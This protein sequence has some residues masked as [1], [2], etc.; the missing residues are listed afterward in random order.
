MS[1]FSPCG[2]APPGSPL[3]C[4]PRGSTCCCLGFCLAPSTFW[5]LA[6]CLSAFGW[7]C[8]GQ[9]L[10]GE[11]PGGQE[12]PGS[13]QC[14]LAGL[15]AHVDV[16]RV[17]TWRPGWQGLGHLN[18]RSCE[19]TPSCHHTGRSH[20]QVVLSPLRPPS[21]WDRPSAWSAGLSLRAPRLGLP[22]S[23]EP[24]R[25]STGGGTVRAWGGV[26]GPEA[27]GAWWAGSQLLARM[28]PGPSTGAAEAGLS[29]C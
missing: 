22:T 4:P 5:V 17:R 14:R 10:A 1:W 24:R 27:E 12:A 19:G 26:G 2:S 21:W 28:C 9:G 7:A 6:K 8:P 3:F 29:L 13:A 20:A 18:T 23:D 16:A 25:G 15:G 11:T